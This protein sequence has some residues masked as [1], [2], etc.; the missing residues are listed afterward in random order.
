MSA[1]VTLVLKRAKLIDLGNFM[2][3]MLYRLN[4]VAANRGF[5]DE[6]AVLNERGRIFKLSGAAVNNFCRSVEVEHIL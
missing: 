5:S 2:R 4:L 6:A 1:Y 3:C